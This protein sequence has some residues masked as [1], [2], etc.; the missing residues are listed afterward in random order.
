LIFVKIKYVLIIVIVKAM[1][2]FKNQDLDL[3]VVNEMIKTV[4]MQIKTNFVG[5]ITVPASI[6]IVG[7]F[8]QVPENF[9]YMPSTLGTVDTDQKLCK[10]P[11]SGRLYLCSTVT[12]EQLDYELN[13]C[14]FEP[15]QTQNHMQTLL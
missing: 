5:L 1:H 9:D 15:T 3:P 10:D 13:V 2:P 11:I 6:T 12:K 7:R 8:L 4:K 14:S